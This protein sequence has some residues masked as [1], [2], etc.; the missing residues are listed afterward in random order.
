MKTYE[1]FFLLDLETIKEYLIHKKYF[2]KD[3]KLESREVGDGNINYVFL[4]RNDRK[5][6][7]VKQADE[8]LRANG[9]PLDSY[10]SKIEYNILKEEERLVPGFVPEIYEYDDVM[11]TIIM[12]DISE[13][14]N[15]RY[16][17]MSGKKFDHFSENI[18]TFL[19]DSLLPTTDLVLDAM[20]KKEKVKKYI[21]KELCLISENLVLTEPYYDYKSQNKFNKENLDFVTKNLYENDAIK[22]EVSKLRNNFMNNAQALIHGDLHS[23]SIFANEKR[24]KV[25]DPEFAFYGPIGYDIGNV[26]ANLFFPLICFENCSWLKDCIVEV[27]DKTFDKM[28]KKYDKI[29]EFP[30][31]RVKTFKDYYIKEIMADTCGYAGTEIIRRTIGDTHVKELDNISAEKEREFVNLGIKL[32]MNRYSIKEGKD[33]F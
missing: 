7:V 22:F 26:I 15:L 16:E 9:R 29:V 17:L 24:I 23:G 18:S 6:I 28:S 13:Y 27:F 10:R 5:S 19:A 21:N 31:Y 1:K 12:E 3:E 2:E 14:K 20:D 25:I 33:L 32:I 11:H 4:V 30:L 8:F